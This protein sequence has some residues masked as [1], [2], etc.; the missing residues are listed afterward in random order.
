MPLRDTPDEENQQLESRVRENR[1]H[2]S[3]GGEGNLPDPYQKHLPPPRIATS[4][5]RASR[6]PPY[7]RN[8]RCNCA[9]FMRL[10]PGTFRRLASW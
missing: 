4:H 1:K 8:A 5:R 7:G 10:R 6:I 2:G 3:E 9:L